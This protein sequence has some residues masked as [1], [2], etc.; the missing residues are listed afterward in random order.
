MISQILQRK[1]NKQFKYFSPR[2]FGQLHQHLKSKLPWYHRWFEWSYHKYV[3]YGLIVLSFIGLTIVFALNAQF[4]RAG[5]SNWIQSDWSGG[6]G[7]STTNQYSSQTNA[8]TST[9]NQVTLATTSNLFTNNNFA[10]DLSNW[11][12]GIPPNKISGL[13]LWLQASSIAQS[14]GTTVSSWP[15]SSTAGNNAIQS[16]GADQPTFETNVINGQ[17]ALLFDGAHDWMAAPSLTGQTIFVVANHTDGGTNF[18][19]YRRMVDNGDTFGYSIFGVSGNSTY[20]P[21]AFPRGITASNFWVNGTNTL[22][23]GTLSTF[24]IVSAVATSPS[25]NTTWIGTYT[26]SGAQL[27]KGNMSEVIIY[28]GALTTA[29]RTGVE[30]YLSSKYGITVSSGVTATRNTTTTYNSASASAKLVSNDAGEFTQ[31][32]TT[33]SGK[34]ILSGYAYT[35]GAAV[36]SSDVQLYFNGSPVT[37]TY[38]SVGSGWYNL[39]AVVNGVSGSAVAGVQEQA[40]KTVYLDGLSMNSY[41][42]SGSVVSNIYNTGVDENWGNMSYSAT[43]PTNT[44]VSVLVRAGNNSNL[45][46]APAFTSCSPINSGSAITSSCAPNKSQ[47]VQYELEFTSDG[48]ATPT[49]SSNTIPYAPSD[50]TPPTTNA[51]GITAQDGPSGANVSSD[52]WANI[53]PYFSW[54][55]GT[56]D[57]GGSGIQGYCLY[58]GQDPTGNPVTTEG[59]LG[60]SP[61]NTGGACQFVVSSTNI[62]TAISGYIGTALASSNS[63]YYLNIKAIDNADN[64]YNGSSAQFEFLYD[65]TPPT[66]PSFITAPS[67]FVSNKQVTLTWST[68]GADAASD[69]N[70][71]VAGLQYRI[72]SGGTWFGANHNGNQNMSDLL[73]NN[74]S[75]TTVSSPDFTNL[76]EGNNIIYFRTWDNAGNVSPANVTTVIKINTTSPSSPQNLTATPTTNTT[77]SF[78]FSWLAPATFTGSAGNIT[79]C[80]T[81]NSLPNVNNCSF[82]G[83]GQTSLDAGA[84]A[85]E[86]G[87]NTFY[88]VAKDEAGNINYATASSV[89][90]TANT[91]APGVP[92]NPDIADISIKSSSS[93]KLALSWDQPSTVGAGIATYKIFRSTDSINYTDIANTAGTSY[94]D[95]NLIQQTYY[96]KVEACDS[97][98]NCG[99]Q[100]SAINDFPTGK[101][102]VPANLIDGP[103]TS[104]NTRS[105]TISWVTDR[106]SD[107]RVEYGLTSNQYSA[108]EAANS[109]Q[110]TSHTINL[111]NL[112]AGTTYYYRTQWDD[113]DGNIGTSPEQIFTTLPAPTVS[114]VTVSDINLSSASI[115]FT[116]SNA[117]SVQLTYGSGNGLGSSQ[118]LNTS[119]STSTYS[120]P[121]KALAS[122][123]T[124]AFKLNPYD[125]SGNIYTSPA[126]YSF[127]TPPQPTITNVQ[128]QPVPGALTGTE[129][130]SWTTNVPTTSQISYGLLNGPRS[131]QL[132]TTFTTTHSMSVAD[133]TYDTQYS[134]TATSVDTLGNVANSDL[135]VFKSGIDTR[136]PIISNVTIQPSIIGNGASAQGQLIVS[137]K[138]DK[139]GTS[140]VAYGDGSAG[141][142]TTRTSE[143]TAIVNNHVVV[144]SGLN[145]AEVYH[146]QVISND[147]DGIKGVSGDQTTIVG[148]ASDNALSIVFNSL[149]SI[150]GL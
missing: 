7:S 147:A 124:Y 60:T 32:T 118:T 28:S 29:Q 136:P 90:F 51:S 57:I 25:T 36:T 50:V 55:A 48:G 107:S 58:L 21:T 105:A 9:A 98:N 132:D 129:Q 86:P 76:V 130:I 139:A 128:F 110:V 37:T 16:T 19:D 73:T 4:A 24:R 10:S 135:Q 117:T 113:I 133:L 67:E 43:V 92:L 84:Y 61:I 3:H 141:N 64:V 41:Q 142:Y 89:N 91:P 66:N 123:T 62:N 78:G 85:T 97:A 63:P 104:V 13:T 94:V 88:L 114:G 47:Y 99:G 2:S 33:G 34:Y 1:K 40:T 138:T 103:T 140:Q 111:N 14:N 20:N 74:G 125:T 127:T 18:T 75:Y 122:G 15:D 70:S 80:Y 101:F 65:N 45:S 87:D 131:N 134:I 120:I 59:D 115:D 44:T 11:N 119:T 79:Y 69:S 126:S 8:T 146:V 109:D 46:D 100:T 81:I 42:L 121:L 150:F 22:S 106:D 112:Q 54:T 38:T 82:T 137:W 71:G 6:V 68:S 39:S 145:T 31:S 26:G 23:A 53:D 83:A 5:G 96:Y 52:G 12:T 95:S 17:P 148:Q 108:T 143:N 102:T 27:F 72:G 116:S 144:V 56:D 49:F 30:N 93:W 77:N 149:Q 35:T